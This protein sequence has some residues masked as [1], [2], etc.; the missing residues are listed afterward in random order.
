MCAVYCVR[1][2]C[3]VSCLT[4]CLR[5]YQFFSV[6]VSIQDQNLKKTTVQKVKVS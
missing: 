4:A 6:K 1:L 3:I 2:E 5:N